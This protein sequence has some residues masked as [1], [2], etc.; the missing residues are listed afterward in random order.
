[1]KKP[2]TLELQHEIDVLFDEILATQDALNKSHSKLNKELKDAATVIKMQ[3]SEI[4]RLKKDVLDA[5][6]KVFNFGI[7]MIKYRADVEEAKVISGF[8]FV[9]GLVAF[10]LALA[11]L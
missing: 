9:I 5:K 4:D 11:A 10:I 8:A 6:Q 3:N 2:D 1:M 7:D